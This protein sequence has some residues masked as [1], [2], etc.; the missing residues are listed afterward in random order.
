MLT[1]KKKDG[2]YAQNTKGEN[3]I[4]SNFCLNVHL[5]TYL[6]EYTDN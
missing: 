3:K 6:G 4:N 1:S 2:M 5:K